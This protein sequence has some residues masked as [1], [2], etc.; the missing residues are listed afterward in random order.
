VSV[1]CVQLQLA[2]SVV[3]TLLRFHLLCNGFK[4]QSLATADYELWNREM[5]WICC[6]SDGG[7]YLS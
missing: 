3:Q 6:W 7:F 4:K 1:I 5:S 2:A